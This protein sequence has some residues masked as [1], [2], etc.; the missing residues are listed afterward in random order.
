[1]W[2][3]MPLNRVMQKSMQCIYNEWGGHVLHINIVIIFFLCPENIFED[4]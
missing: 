2:H 1:M 3:I 4:L